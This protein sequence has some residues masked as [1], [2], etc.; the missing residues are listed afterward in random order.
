MEFKFDIR[1]VATEEVL[2]V[3]KTLTAEGRD[4]NDEWVYTFEHGGY[5]TESR[6]FQVF[7]AAEI[8]MTAAVA[9]AQERQVRR[10][11]TRSRPRTCST[12]STRVSYWYLVFH[13]L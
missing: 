11:M 1:D 10:V 4:A 6:Y 8:Q 9:A 12:Y 3:D 13:H 2:K 5:R 7:L